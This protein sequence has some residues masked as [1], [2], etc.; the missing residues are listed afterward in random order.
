M[1]AEQFEQ[2]LH[3]INVETMD[4]VRELVQRAQKEEGLEWDTVEPVSFRDDPAWQNYADGFAE[5]CGWI[6]DRLNGINRLHKKSMTKKIR[7]VLG[8]TYP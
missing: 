3:K 2:E 7:K 6:Y 4:K 8:Y 1:K 5:M